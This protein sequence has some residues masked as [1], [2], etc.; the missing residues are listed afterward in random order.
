[1][2]KVLCVILS[3]FLTVCLSGCNFNT[4]EQQTEGNDGRMTLIYNDGWALIYKDNETGVQY[5]RVGNGVAV[6]VNTDGTP[7]TGESK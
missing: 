6:M 3:F 2:K 7:Y 4:F 5:L 1:M